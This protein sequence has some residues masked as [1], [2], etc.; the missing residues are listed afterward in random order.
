VRRRLGAFRN[1]GASGF[2]AGGASAVNLELTPETFLEAC[3]QENARRLSAFDTRLLRP[4][5]M[6]ALARA[7]LRSLR[8]LPA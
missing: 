6:P 8:A 2:T 5:L 1:A 3:L 7:T 4:R